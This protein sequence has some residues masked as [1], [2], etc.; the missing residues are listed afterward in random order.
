[1]ATID[2]TTAPSGNDRCTVAAWANLAQND[3]GAAI[4]NSQYADRSFQVAG[5][6]GGASVSIE[7]TNDGANWATLTDPQG[8]ALTFT[9]AKIEMVSEATLRIRPKVT[10][11]D[12]T[13]SLTVSALLKE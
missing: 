4:G 5:T 7:G 8:N 6:F 11:G 13:T 2:Y 9:S 3:I 10:G 12:G 1:M